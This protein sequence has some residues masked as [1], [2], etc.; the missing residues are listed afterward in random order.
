MKRVLAYF[1]LPVLLVSCAGWRS[2]P[3]RIESFVSDLE[4]SAQ[5]YEEA[6][7]DNAAAE[8]HKL[9]DTYYEH[10]NDYSSEERARIQRAAGKYRALLFVN[11]IK[12]VA[13]SVDNLI[14]SA[15]SYLEGINDVMKEKTSQWSEALD[16][17]DLELSLE[18]FGH[19][20][21]S[22]FNQLSDGVGDLLERMGLK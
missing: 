14:S 6:D 16:F 4:Y 21:D 8:Y 11:G 20:V 7:W 18:S 5:S 3:D 17:S 9:M 19:D 12:G 1:I 10:K 15:P 2:L 22:L 13:S